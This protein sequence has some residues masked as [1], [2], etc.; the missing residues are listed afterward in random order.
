MKPRSAFF[1]LV[2]LA[3]LLPT[4]S[5]PAQTLQLG[6]KEPHSFSLIEEND[7]FYDPAPGKHQDRHY[8]QG[9]KAIYSQP[10]QDAP[11]SQWLPHVGISPATSNTVV[12]ILGQSIFTPEDNRAA[13]LIKNDRPYAGWL[14]AGAALQ[15]RG[16]TARGT[17]VL[18]SFDLDLGVV[19]P[20]AL[21]E[22]AQNTLHSWRHLPQF[23][24]W[25]HQLKTEPDFVLKYG[26]AWKLGLE[27]DTCHFE[28]I[29]NIGTQLGTLRVSGNAGLAVR[30]GF[31]LPD[32][33]GIQTIDSPLV[34]SSGPARSQFS[35]YL[36]AQAEANVVGRNVFLDGNL[37]QSSPSIRKKTLVGDYLYGVGLTPCRH[38]E[39]SWSFDV[40]TYEFT[41]QQ[42]NDQFGSVALKF[43]WAF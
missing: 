1:L 29:P 34:I 27:N 35:L 8:T 6:G 37:Y 26:R 9:L 7:L 16:L 33:F 10:W 23:E 43:L 28:F 19:G 12:W 41:G 17:P 5:S 42:A 25:G 11:F 13:N 18:E 38:F 15:R 3:C 31:N 2:I 30:F 20:Q 14:Y 40:R 24:G 39:L 22:E 32:D 21:G 4:T 36:F